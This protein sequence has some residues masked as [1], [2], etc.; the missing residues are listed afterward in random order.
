MCLLFSAHTNSPSLPPA[1]AETLST[2]LERFNIRVTIAVPGSFATK[3]NA[4]TRRERRSRA[5][6]RCATVWT[7][8]YRTTPREIPK[9]DPN[10]GMSALVNVVRR[11][12]RAADHGHPPLWLFLGEDSMRDLQFAHA[13]FPV[14]ARGVEGR[15]VEF[16]SSARAAS[17]LISIRKM[18]VRRC[19]ATLEALT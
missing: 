17:G 18:E 4:P 11:E 1:Y 3:I 19:G 13:G 2:E 5:T 9:G 14:G 12:G 7:S 10:L 6:S 8:S 16:G 15:R